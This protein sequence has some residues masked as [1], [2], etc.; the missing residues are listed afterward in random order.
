MRKLFTLLILV[1]SFNSYSQTI[2]WNNIWGKWDYRDS[3]RSSNLKDLDSSKVLATDAKGKFYLKTSTSVDTT[4]R[5][6]NS[7]TVLTDSTIR[8]CKGTT[9]TTYTMRG[10]GSS[11]GTPTNIYNSDGSLD[12]T[13]TVTLNSGS[14]LDIVTDMVD[15]VGVHIKA[16]GIFVGD[17]LRVSTGGASIN[18]SNNIFRVSDLDFY[19]SFLATFQGGLVIN[20]LDTSN[21]DL[22]SALVVTPDGAGGTVKKKAFYT[23]AQVRAL[24]SDSINIYK[25]TL[26]A[27]LGLEFENDSTIRVRQSFLD[28]L[29]ALQ[30]IDTVL[31]RNQPL[32]TVREINTNGQTLKIGD[33]STKLSV[34]GS[35]VDIGDVDGISD[36]QKFHF[37]SDLS[38]FDITA[39][40][41]KVGINTT[42]PQGELGVIGS[43]SAGNLIFNG[44]I[45]N[46][47]A[48]ATIVA[49]SHNILGGTTSPRTVTFVGIDGGGL[50][51]SDLFEIQVGNDSGWSS[52][53]DLYMSD[54]S[55]FTA[56]AANTMYVIR[57][58]NAK[59][60]VISIL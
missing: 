19:T 45:F 23:Q 28:S 22:D 47:D 48:N 13:R 1:T 21:S 29:L 40:N 11:G 33:G 2:P 44:Q 3:I 6:V 12:T 53:D 57:Y 39:H 27:G 30:G 42:N 43:I 20:F 46:S 25:K 52:V 34:S 18:G 37:Q 32:T 15:N 17:L 41:Y 49:G 16:N 50:R 10:A 54:N 7:V 9:C 24:I 58:Y 8:V 51:N 5:F 14:R 55:T 31:S 26:V 4:N 35:G 56:L 38:Y 36:G 59:L 60:Q